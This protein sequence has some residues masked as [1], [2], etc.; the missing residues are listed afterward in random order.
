MIRGL[1]QDRKTREAGGRQARIPCRRGAYS[2][3]GHA[4]VFR[5]VQLAPNPPSPRLLLLTSKVVAAGERQV[6][7]TVRSHSDTSNNR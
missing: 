1:P 6:I 3:L 5:G 4:S 2:G 7:R